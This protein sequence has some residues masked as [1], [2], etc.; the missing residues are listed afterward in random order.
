MEPL[1]LSTRAAQQYG[2]VIGERFARVPMI[3][4]GF[5]GEMVSLTD[6]RLLMILGYWIGI[7]GGIEKKD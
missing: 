1:Y 3:D 7:R 4:S 5:T 6:R 2:K